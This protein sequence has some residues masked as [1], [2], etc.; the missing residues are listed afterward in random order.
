MENIT[1]WFYH[2][3]E[4]SG[5][6]GE[7]CFS[8]LVFCSFSGGEWYFWMVPLYNCGKWQKH[9]VKFILI[10]EWLSLFASE[11]KY[12]CS[13]QT[14]C[15]RLQCVVIIKRAGTKWEQTMSCVRPFCNAAP[16]SNLSW[17]L[18]QPCE[19]NYRYYPQL[20]GE[21]NRRINLPKAIL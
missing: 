3:Y 14:R 20:T 9:F 7:L 4:T 5:K 1:E 21:N 16:Q 18:Q 19:F 12:A 2:Q 8:E 10:K 13:I 11:T 17:S 6:D 15:L